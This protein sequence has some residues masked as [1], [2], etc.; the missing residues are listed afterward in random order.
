MS[1]S[2]SVIELLYSLLYKMRISA[3]PHS[4]NLSTSSF[5]FCPTCGYFSITEVDEILTVYLLSPSVP[6]LPA[7]MQPTLASEGR[8][9]AFPSLG[10]SVMVSGLS[11]MWKVARPGAVRLHCLQSSKFEFFPDS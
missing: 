7:N 9:F 5:L 3:I 1:V 11:P 10:S 6:R 4:F 8:R 2:P